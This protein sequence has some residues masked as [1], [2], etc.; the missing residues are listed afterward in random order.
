VHRIRRYVLKQG[1][2][3]EDPLPGPSLDSTMMWTKYRKLFINTVVENTIVHVIG[4]IASTEAFEGYDSVLNLIASMIK[5]T[6]EAYTGLIRRR[7]RESISRHLDNV[8]V[9]LDYTNFDLSRPVRTEDL[10]ES[11]YNEDSAAVLV[12]D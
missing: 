5:T 12:D 11:E 10:S 9:R 1:G 2:E 6:R 3:D 4:A 8:V 7:K